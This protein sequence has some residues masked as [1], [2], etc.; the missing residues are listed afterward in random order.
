VTSSK[1]ETQKNYNNLGPKIYDKRYKQ[2]QKIKYSI[3][4]NNLNLLKNELI[5]DHGC[6]TGLFVELIK[7][8]IVGIDSSSSLLI[9]ALKKVKRKKN[10]YLVKGDVDHLPFKDNIFQKLFSFTVIQNIV[11]PYDTLIE[12][13]R[14]TEGLK[15]ITVLKKTYDQ[16]RL[17]CLI[18]K[19]NLENTKII[20]REE[21]KDWILLV[22]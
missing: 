6:G 10:K 12:I 2:E 15:I 14:V 16:K 22:E 13:L 18:E 1:K 4:L 7:N 20:N 3:V 8:P 9:G 19:S 11:N 17:M 5:L 21:S